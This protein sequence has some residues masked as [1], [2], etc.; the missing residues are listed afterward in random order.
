MANTTTLQNDASILKKAKFFFDKVTS[1]NGHDWL[2][3]LTWIFVFEFLSSILEYS[4]LEVA[5]NYIYHI[6]QSVYKEIGI[7]L[8][9]VA[10][11]WYTVY[12][13]VFMKRHQFFY[14]ALFGSVGLYLIV[15]HD[16][17]FNLLVHNVMN[18]FE[19]EFNSFGFYVI[20]Q[21]FIK[22]VITYLIFM[23]LIAIKNRKTKN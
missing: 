14:L 2:L 4:Y 18:P 21:L 16:V 7:A 22:A 1:N 15:T 3:A 17:T 23:M 6:P 20:A 19:F 12:M 8:L 10:F 9:I 11:I 5:Q 13:I